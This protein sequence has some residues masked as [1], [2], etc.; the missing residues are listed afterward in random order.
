M[1]IRTFIRRELK[2]MR[3]W[4]DLEDETSDRVYSCLDDDSVNP[5]IN[6]IDIPEEL[7]SIVSEF[8]SQLQLI[9]G[10]RN[11]SGEPEF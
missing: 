2:E 5:T 8:S 9:S 4:W 10:M 11:F 1:R 6:G 3:G 7:H